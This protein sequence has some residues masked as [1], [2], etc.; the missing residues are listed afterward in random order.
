MFR[1]SD[2]PT[3]PKWPIFSSIV[4]IPH[5]VSQ[6]INLN[7]A[8]TDQLIE[9]LREKVQQHIPEETKRSNVLTKLNELQ[10]AP[11]KPTRLE[12]YTQ[13]IGDHITMLTF[14]LTPLLRRLMN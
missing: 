9:R 3:P 2:W 7:T 10:S 12:R 14:V 6:E 13:L 4:A 11:D 8:N 1:R 5:H